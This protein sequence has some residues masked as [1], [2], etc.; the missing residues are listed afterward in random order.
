MTGCD[1]C[2]KYRKDPLQQI[3]YSYVSR[4]VLY[5]LKTD[6]IY[7]HFNMVTDRK[8]LKTDCTG[9]ATNISLEQ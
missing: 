9:I 8:Y 5:L 4:Y 2:S 6:K 3:H 1:T 7:D